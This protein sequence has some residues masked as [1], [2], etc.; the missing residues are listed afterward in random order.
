MFTNAI[1]AT[2]AFSPRIIK[3]KACCITKQR[4]AST[5]LHL[6]DAIFIVPEPQ[7][8]L[9]TSDQNAVASLP[10]TAHIVTSRSQKWQTKPLRSASQRCPLVAHSARSR[11]GRVLRDVEGIKHRCRQQI[12]LQQSPE[13]QSYRDTPDSI[14]LSPYSRAISSGFMVKSW[15][16]SLPSSCLILL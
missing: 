1:A 6:C 11:G 12:L 8:H 5:F 9:I 3:A 13:K 16:A 4:Y 10:Q 7:W 15:S 14:S 2:A